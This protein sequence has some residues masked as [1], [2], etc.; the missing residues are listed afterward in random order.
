MGF[1]RRIYSPGDGTFANCPCDGCD[2]DG[3]GPGSGDGSG[4]PDADGKGGNP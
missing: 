2:V 3:A 1:F 4:N